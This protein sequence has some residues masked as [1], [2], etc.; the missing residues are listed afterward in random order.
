MDLVQ[1]GNIGLMKAVERFEYQRGLRFS[2]YATWWI[3]QGIT[4]AL[5]NQSRTIRI[6]VHIGD[7]HRQLTRL[8]D[9]LRAE[10]HR[11]PTDK[12]LAR[13]S[14]LSERA[15]RLI[16]R[17]SRNPR[18]LDEP[19]G[20][21]SVLGEFVE[22]RSV[23]SAL[24]AAARTEVASEVHRAITLLPAREREILRLHFGLD[25]ETEHTLTEIGA[26]LGVTRERARQLEVRALQSLSRALLMSARGRR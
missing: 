18:S 26:R 16:E 23:P 13:Q 19:I 2:T 6:P 5:A 9:R 11:E 17:A 21:D 15:V 7:R 12:D 3:R 1:E 20:G 22:D 8:R 10:R 25:G 4:R 24:E 14:G